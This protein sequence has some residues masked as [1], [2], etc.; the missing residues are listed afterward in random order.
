MREV[1]RYTLIVEIVFSVAFFIG[2]LYVYF[3]FNRKK[4]PYKNGG[5]FI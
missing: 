2:A 5:G 1:I 3:K 4:K